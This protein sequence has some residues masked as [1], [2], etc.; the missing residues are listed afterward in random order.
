MDIHTIVSTEFVE[1]SPSTRVSKLAG[2]FDDRSVDGVVVTDDE[3]YQGVVTRRQMTASHYHPDQKVA[4]LVWHVPRVE[5]TADV[6]EV[7][8]L[9]LDGDTRLLPVFEAERLVGVVTVDDVLA[10]VLPFLDA[11]T[12]GDVVTTDLVTVSPDDTF[13]RTVHLFHEH[14]FT[15]LP[16]VEGDEAV[17]ILSLYDVTDLAARAVSRSQGG[18]PGEDLVSSGRTHGGYGAREGELEKM[19][20]LPVRDVMVSPV[21]HVHPEETLQAAVERMFDK[22]C[23]SL[24]VTTDG[25]PWG[26]VTKSDVLAALTWETDD[27]RAVQVYGTDLLDDTTYADVVEVINGLDAKAADVSILDAKLHLHKHDEKLRGTPLLLAR[28]RLYT[29]SGVFVASAEGFGAS[30]ALNEVRDVMERRI[31][32]EKS[33]GRSKKHP[34]ADYW[35]RRFGWRLEE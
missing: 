3:G 20:D 11:A 4:S 18:D 28:L 24:V 1:L 21:E 35:N 5:P 31:R 34:D 25:S 6:R 7:A 15:H 22:E 19:L 9:M 23:S 27:T 33:Y 10:A 8:R 17:G 29:D 30:H 2:I 26:I 16:V 13:G 32:D 14:R 12:V